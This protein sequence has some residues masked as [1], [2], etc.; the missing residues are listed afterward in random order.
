MDNPQKKIAILFRQSMRQHFSS[1]T[2]IA[3]AGALAIGFIACAVMAF[4]CFEITGERDAAWDRLKDDLVSGEFA[5]GEEVFR[6]VVD[7]GKWPHSSRVSDRDVASPDV[8]AN[9][10]IV[11]KSLKSK[12][13]VINLYCH[14]IDRD[15][16]VHSCQII[17]LNPARPSERWPFVDKA[18]LEGHIAAVRAAAGNKN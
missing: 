18:A 8:D 9:L 12:Q 6:L 11:L 3:I 1:F 10:P 17:S 14:T 2:E 13:R 15:L 16:V 4:A 5:Q 7:Y